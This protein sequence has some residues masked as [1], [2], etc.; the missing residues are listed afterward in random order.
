MEVYERI[1]MIRN[2]F[3]MSQEQFGEALGV[4]RSVIANIEYDRLR[5]PD[6]KEPIYRLICEKFSVNENWLRTGEG[7]MLE[8]SKEAYIAEFIGRVFKDKEDTFKKRFIAMLS[9]LDEDG[10]KALEEVAEA[11]NALKKD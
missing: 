10:W 3:N 7:E 4:S 11:M 8:P 6:Q 9:K 2:H 5:R 1:K